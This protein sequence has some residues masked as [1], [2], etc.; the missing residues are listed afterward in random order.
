MK[1]Q[2][3]RSRMK[4]MALAAALVAASCAASGTDQPATGAAEAIDSVVPSAATPAVTVGEGGSARVGGSDVD[5]GE[6]PGVVAPVGESGFVFVELGSDFGC[7]LR[8]SGDVACWGWNEF[9]Q[10]SPPPEPVSVLAVG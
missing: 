3:G 5:G 6:S 9:G 7:A 4:R 2:G 8:G 10:A 1:Y